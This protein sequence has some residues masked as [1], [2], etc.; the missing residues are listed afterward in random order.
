[1]GRAPH[2]GG[3]RGRLIVHIS[4]DQEED[5]DQRQLSAQFLL[6][7]LPARDLITVQGIVCLYS[8]RSSAKPCRTP[9]RH[10]Q[11][12]FLSL[13]PRASHDPLQPIPCPIPAFGSYSPVLCPV[14]F[15]YLRYRMDEIRLSVTKGAGILHWA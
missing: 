9:H 6:H 12:Y 5:R 15:L 1:M 10:T 8:G 7:F 14:A 2:C 11:R 13:H 4:E 3:R